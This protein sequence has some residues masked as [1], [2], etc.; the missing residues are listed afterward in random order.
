MIKFHFPVRKFYEFSF[1]RQ[2]QISNY[3]YISFRPPQFYIQSVVILVFNSKTFALSKKN[4]LGVSLKINVFF[5]G[6]KNS[7]INYNC[8]KAIRYL[9]KTDFYQAVL[10]SVCLLSFIQLSSKMFIFIFK[11]QSSFSFG[12]ETTCYVALK[13]V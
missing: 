6:Q 13:T 5:S 12:L 1:Y 3:C 10:K 11:S 4:T 9:K 2:E 8:G 7:K